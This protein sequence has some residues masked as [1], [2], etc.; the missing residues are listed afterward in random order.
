MRVPHNARVWNYWLNGKENYDADRK[1]AEQIKAMYPSIVDVARAD[2]QFLSRV[3]R[4]L[5]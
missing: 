2:R 4:F 3:V 1:V 5:I